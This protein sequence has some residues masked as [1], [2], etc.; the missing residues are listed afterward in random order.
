M[1]TR[2][3]KKILPDANSNEGG[4]YV[5]ELESS[6]CH[7]LKPVAVVLDVFHLLRLSYRFEEFLGAAHLTSFAPRLAT[8]GLLELSLLPGRFVLA[9]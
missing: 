4:N 5:A 9:T 6:N 1:L 7:P 3:K 8:Q 2:D